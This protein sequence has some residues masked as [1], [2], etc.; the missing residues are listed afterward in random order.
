VDD[1]QPGIALL[2]TV[3]RRGWTDG[4]SVNDWSRPSV[5]VWVHTTDAV[6][7]DAGACDRMINPKVHTC[8]VTQAPQYSS[9]HLRATQLPLS[10]RLPAK[11]NGIQDEERDEHSSGCSRNPEAD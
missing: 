3:R 5:A 6:Y 10:R 8:P 7:Q 11:L 2:G 4:A 1:L 9:G